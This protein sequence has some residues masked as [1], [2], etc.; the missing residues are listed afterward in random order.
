MSIKKMLDFLNQL[1]EQGSWLA[2]KADEF[3]VVPVA[4]VF[5]RPLD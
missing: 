3:A 1:V 2:D 5:D 4:T